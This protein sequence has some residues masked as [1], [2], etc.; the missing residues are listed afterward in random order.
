LSWITRELAPLVAVVAATLG[1]DGTLLE[2]NAGFLRIAGLTDEPTPHARVPRVFVQP[3]FLDLVTAATGAD[4]EVYRG[5]MTMGSELD[6]T[7]TLRGRVWRVGETLR[8]LAEYDIAELEQLTAKM[9][10]FNRDYAAAQFELAQTNLK[11][12]Q[13]EAQIVAL[14]LTDSLTGVGNHRRFERDLTT[15]IERFERTGE[16]LSALMADLD[17]FKGINDNFGHE[18]G[19]RVLAAFGDLLLV[20]VRATEIATRIGG[21]EFVVLLPHTALD[22]ARTTAERLR[23]ATSELRIAGLP[24]DVTASFGVAAMAPGEGRVAFMR[25]LDQALYQAKHAGRNCVATG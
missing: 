4:G 15:E 17:H 18:A 25:R 23:A 22:E 24:I 21:E 14:T 8:V 2:A 6:D 13:R 1:A 7:Q 19:D 11:L 3:K 9:L 16:P 10:G 5:L 20:Q 12:Q